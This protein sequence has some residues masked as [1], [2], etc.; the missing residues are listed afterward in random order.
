MFHQPEL[1]W[2]SHDSGSGSESKGP[3]WVPSAAA[4]IFGVRSRL[5]GPLFGGFG[6]QSMAAVQLK[7]QKAELRAPQFE[8]RKRDSESR[9]P[10]DKP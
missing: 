8:N 3:R 7:L 1:A 2:M 9:T 6:A 5:A 4:D 10:K